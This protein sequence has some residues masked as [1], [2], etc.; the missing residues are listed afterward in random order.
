MDVRYRVMKPK[1][2]RNCV[3][4]IAAHPVLG[5]RYGSLIEQLPSAI[6]SVFGQDS[7][8]AVVFEEFQGSEPRFLGAGLAAFVSDEFFHELKTTPHFWIGPELV[9]RITRGTSPLLSD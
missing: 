8:I 2:V 6:R 5:E 9:K 1:D 3:E 7:F 4:G